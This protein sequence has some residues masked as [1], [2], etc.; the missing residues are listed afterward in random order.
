MVT[1]TKINDRRQKNSRNN[2]NTTQLQSENE[3]ENQALPSFA[4]KTTHQKRLRQTRT[5]TDK[6]EEPEH[7]NVQ[8]V[9]KKEWRVTE[10]LRGPASAK[11]PESLRL[12]WIAKKQLLKSTE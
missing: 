5:L 9:P 3:K 4:R 10:V 1:T 8:L 7:S 12:R 6:W 11:K 2:N